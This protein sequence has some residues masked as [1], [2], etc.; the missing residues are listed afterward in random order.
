MD[1]SS[2][3]AQVLAP[4]QVGV[5]GRVLAGE[6]DLLPDCVRLAYDGKAEHLGP[7]RVRLQDRRQDAD[8]RRLA[9]AIR[10]EQPEDGAGRDVEVDSVERGDGVEPLGE[11]FD[12]DCNVVHLS[13]F[14]SNSSARLKWTGP[15]SL[16]E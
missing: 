9:G 8:R 6:A 5:H 7:A 10:P 12:S 11:S 15:A 16:G 4:G 13:P 2:D 1:E 14:R 3:Q